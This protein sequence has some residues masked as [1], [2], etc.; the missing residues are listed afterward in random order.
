MSSY[1]VRSTSFW[2][3]HLLLLY[4]SSETGKRWAKYIV[5]LF[6]LLSSAWTHI[7]SNWLHYC[8]WH[9]VCGLCSCWTAAWTGSLQ[10]R[11]FHLLA[12]HRYFSFLVH[13]I[14]SRNWLWILLFL[15]SF[16][17]GHPKFCS[18]SFQVKV[19]S[20]NLSRLLR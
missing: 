5:Y 11:K 3:M 18:R 15:F 14:Y 17:L 10:N 16:S 9:L 12:G 4:L 20:I 19:E 13:L 1:F 7:W 8:N 6:S 2:V